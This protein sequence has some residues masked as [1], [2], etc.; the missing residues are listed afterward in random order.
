MAVRTTLLV[1]SV[2]CF[3]LFAV[4]A[5]IVI[6]A[7]RQGYG[8]ELQTMPYGLGFAVIALISLGCWLFLKAK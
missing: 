8:V 4:T 3:V 6:A 2:V 5:T 7:T 1:L